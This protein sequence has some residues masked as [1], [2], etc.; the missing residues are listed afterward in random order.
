MLRSI[1]R[2]TTVIWLAAFLVLAAAGCNGAGATDRPSPGSTGV[3]MTEGQTR[4]YLIA[5]LGPLWYCDSDSYPV[6]RDEQVA[7]LD[8]Y[9]EMTAGQDLFVSAAVAAGVDPGAQHTDAQKLAIY[10]KWKVATAVQLDPMGTGRWRF[11]YLAQPAAG[12]AEG[13]R[14]AGIID[15]QGHVTIEQQ[16]AAG[17]PMCPICLAI[18][19][20]IDT[21]HGSIGVDRLRL[22]DTVWT[23]DEGGR[24]VPGTVIALGSTP[25]PAD[26]HLID[27]GLADGRS[28]TASPG[29]P[30][31][32]GRRLADLV[33]GDDVD[34]SAVVHVERLAYAGAETYDLVV[35][36]ETGT[37]LAGGIPLR[38]TLD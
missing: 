32:D 21:P 2:R 29:H 23:L 38:S 27:V 13:T 34:G 26:H 7:A 25:A 20:R 16:A 10:R 15:D 17:E 37:Y 3:P 33:V 11:D 35:S 12:A 30:L 9:Q 14:S 4:L 8:R 19:T 5:E 18:G 28:I 22:G 31:A 6:A 1:D 24:H 36:G